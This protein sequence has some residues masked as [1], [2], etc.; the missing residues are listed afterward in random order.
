[1]NCQICGVESNSKYC[2]EC[3]KIL[4]EVVRRVGEARWNAM[5]DCSFIYPMIKRVAKGE[6]TV[7]DIIQ[8]LE[9]ED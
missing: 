6:L 7:N 5:E 9:R 3:E 4:N 1:M 2:Q 8:Q